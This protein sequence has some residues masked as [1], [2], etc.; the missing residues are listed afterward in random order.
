MIQSWF[1]WNFGLEVYVYIKK[2]AVVETNNESN[3][4]I[5]RKGF[6]ML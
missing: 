6:G 1:M 5:S 2:S 4:G 3:M